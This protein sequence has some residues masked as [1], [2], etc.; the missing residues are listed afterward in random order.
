MK[1]S[2][3][4]LLVGGLLV[5]SCQSD[6]VRVED[7]VR[8]TIDAYMSPNDVERK[9]CLSGYEQGGRV[10]VNDAYQAETVYRDTNRVKAWCEERDG[11]VGHVHNHP[12]GICK[13]SETDSAYAL[14]KDEVDVHGVVCETNPLEM[15]IDTVGEYGKNYVSD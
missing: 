12:S 6:P 14:M 7:S 3:V 2:L 8:D 15:T 13:Y 4:S 11:F 5:G 1:R 9:L 10:Y